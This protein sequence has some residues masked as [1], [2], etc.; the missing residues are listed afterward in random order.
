MNTK[1]KV[2]FRSDNSTSIAHSTFEEFISNDYLQ[3]GGKAIVHFDGELGKRKH[4]RRMWEQMAKAEGMEFNANGVG[5]VI[6]SNP[7]KGIRELQKTVLL[8]RKNPCPRPA[9]LCVENTGTTSKQNTLSSS[10]RKERLRNRS[11]LKK[12][13]RWFLRN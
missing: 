3:K 10:T 9:R 5:I 11:V 12:L 8:L 2:I 1:V 7:V 6:Y 4:F 13:W